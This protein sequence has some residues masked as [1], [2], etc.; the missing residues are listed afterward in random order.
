MNLVISAFLIT[1]GVGLGVLALAVIAF[2]GQ[3]ALIALLERLE[4][5]RH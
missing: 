3:V 5:D 1:V 2:V 4:R